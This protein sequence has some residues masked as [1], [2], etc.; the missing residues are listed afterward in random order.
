MNIG[1]NFFGPK[2]ILYKDFEGTVSKL[3]SA[4]FNTAELCICFGTD[5]EPS[6]NMKK[7]LISAAVQEVTGGIW[8]E[9]AADAR[10]ARVREL[11]MTVNSAHLMILNSSPEG[12]M[13]TLPK[14]AAFGQRNQLKYFVISLMK[15]VEGIQ[16][17]IP[18]LNQYC[19]TLGRA[20]MQFVYHNHEIECIAEGGTTALD[21]MM[22]S[23]PLLKLELD[24]G[25][26]KF[27]KTCPL[28]WMRKYKDRLVLLHLKDIREDACEQNRDECFTAIGEGCIPLKE[29]MQEIKAGYAIDDFGVII[30][31]DDSLTGILEDLE[32][33]ARNINSAA[34]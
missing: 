7:M 29:I 12:M 24:V 25:W 33:G 11:G 9:S 27:A 28:E 20:G 13:E 21:Y 2:K 18:V 5:E 6:E 4:G 10:L 1:V 31:Q 16:P 3:L 19:E 30:D 17:Y 34:V 22:E 14:I 23:C 26:A 8:P 15:N 32:I